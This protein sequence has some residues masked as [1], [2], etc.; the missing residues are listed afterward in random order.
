MA[1]AARGVLTK[2]LRALLIHHSTQGTPNWHQK[3]MFL[4]RDLTYG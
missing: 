3:V 2:Q 4:V 1:R